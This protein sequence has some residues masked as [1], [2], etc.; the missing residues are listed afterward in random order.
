MARQ[1]A[2]RRRYRQLSTYLS[3]PALCAVLLL[4]S[5]PTLLADV[6]IPYT[7]LG[8]GPAS[9]GGYAALLASYNKSYVPYNESYPT[10]SFGISLSLLSATDPGY[11]DML[12][13]LVDIINLRGGVRVNGVPHYIS[14]T[15]SIDDGSPTLTRLVYTDMINSGNYTAYMSPESDA[16]LQVLLPLLSES[17]A[18]MFAMLPTDP[19]DYSTG[20]PY[21]YSMISTDDVMFNAA[22]DE[23]NARAQQYVADGGEGSVHGISTVCMLTVNESLPEVRAAG[24][25]QWI[26]TENARRNNTDDIDVLLDGVW[27][28]TPIGYSNYT[29]ALAACPDGVDLMVLLASDSDGYD[30]VLALQASQLRPKAVLGLSTPAQLNVFDPSQVAVAAG[31]LLPVI[32][33]FPPSSLYSMGGVFYDQTDLATG[34]AIW[35]VGAEVANDPQY[36]Y[37]YGYAVSVSVLLVALTIANSTQPAD[38]RAAVLSLDGQTSVL[39]GIQF[40]ADNVNVYIAP[41]VGQATSSGSLSTGNCSVI[42]YPYDCQPTDTPVALILSASNCSTRTHCSPVF[43]SVRW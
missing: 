13:Y 22:L 28:S 7:F 38:L 37:A 1:A 3:L 4:C 14:F 43:V 36:A 24:V 42:Q 17:N 9:P 5:L 21:L 23:V 10:I 39:G 27:T 16:L 31:W 6:A 25:R 18:T 32:T 30:A 19:D 33:E 15:F 2:P 40:N 26:E 29:D 8:P 34:N 12:A 11:D 20:Y 35:R 41:L